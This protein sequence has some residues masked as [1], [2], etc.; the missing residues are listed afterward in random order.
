MILRSTLLCWLGTLIMLGPS[1]LFASSP[2]TQPL[3][4]HISTFPSKGILEKSATAILRA[5]YHSMGISIEVHYLP[6]AR[7]IVE[8]NNGNMDGEL[9]RVK[10]LEKKFKDL[11]QVKTAILTT[12]TS[13]FT[14]FKNSHVKSWQDLKPYTIA[15]T[16][17]F[18]L[19][20]LNT[21]NSNVIHTRDLNHAFR[22]LINKKVEFVIDSKLNGLQIINNKNISGIH[23]VSPPLE[24]TQVFHYLNSK[25]KNL[26]LKLEESL[27]QLKA[28]GEADLIR[29][30]I[31]LQFLSPN[32]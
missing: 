12:H 18:K 8:A 24:S 15:Y 17:G 26:I 22:L 21:V 28:S 6:G 14:H 16:L 3:T 5:A 27:I 4:L 9:F 1:L 19:A 30:S 23:L 31:T 10:G 25:H 7:S 29:N 13:A 32:E 11:I 2:Q 20:E